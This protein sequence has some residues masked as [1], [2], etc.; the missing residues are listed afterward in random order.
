MRE[1]GMTK[2]AHWINQ[3]IEELSQENG[4]GKLTTRE[5]RSYFW[6]EFK[7]KI[8]ENKKLLKINEEIKT[9]CQKFPTP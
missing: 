3:V 5:S 2:I 6:K 1:K 8:K 7:R 4:F 9:F